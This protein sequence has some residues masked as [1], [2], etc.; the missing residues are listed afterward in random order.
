MPK[1]QGQGLVAGLTSWVEQGKG[2]YLRPNGEARVFQVGR[3]NPKLPAGP[4]RMVPLTEVFRQ[5]GVAVL[6]QCARAAGEWVT[7]DEI[8]FLE[9]GC[10]EYCRALL[11]LMEDKRLVA[12]VRKQDLPFICELCRRPDSFVV[13]LDRPYGQAGCVI[14]ASGL[15]R[16]FGGNKLLAELNGRPLIR[17]ALDATAGLFARRVVVTRHPEVARLAEGQGVRTV[18]HTLPDRSDTVRLGLQDLCRQD[19]PQ[20]L[21]GCLFCPADQ[22]LL[23]RQ[24][25]ASL[26]VCAASQ[27]QTIWRTGWSGRPGAPVLF[28][29]WSFAELMT[30]PRGRGGGAVIQAHPDRVGMVAVEDGRELADVDTPQQLNRLRGCEGLAEN[31]SC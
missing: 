21:S 17:Y 27:P 15:G 13:D 1:L 18:L 4:G 22:P 6:R 8:G 30:L 24:T 25:V 29:A 3:V 11:D 31:S 23:R 2:V 20:P 7:V 12:V 19:S 26:A 9:T 16:R 14:M 10:P 5:Q 28:P